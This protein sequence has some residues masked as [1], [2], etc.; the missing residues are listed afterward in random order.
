MRLVDAVE[1]LRSIRHFLMKLALPQSDV[2]ALLEDCE[3]IVMQCLP[4]LRA[5]CFQA[6][7]GLVPFCPKQTC[8]RQLYLDQAPKMFDVFS[9]D[10]TWHSCIQVMEGHTDR[11]RDQVTCSAG[12]R[13]IASASNDHSIRIWS[14]SGAHLHT[15]EGH[16]AWATSVVF[17]DPRKQVFSGSQDGRIK[18]WDVMTGA[19]VHTWNVQPGVRAL[20]CPHSGDLVAVASSNDPIS[21]WDTW[22]LDS[23]PVLLEGHSTWSIV[24]SIQSLHDSTRL[25]SGGSDGT[26][27]LRD[28]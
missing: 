16:S 4:G 13:D 11:V 22:R 9:L 1:C 14:R 3:R 8:F 15:L 7:C 19:C 23:S 17:S 5:S 2:P 18:I 20:T 21:I 6:Y 25:L 28:I 26:C 12:N 27:K 24:N 10:E